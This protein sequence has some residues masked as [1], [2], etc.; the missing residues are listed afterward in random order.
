MS[1]FK[2]RFTNFDYF[3]NTLRTFFVDKKGN[4]KKDK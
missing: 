4:L 1:D 3:V 2:R